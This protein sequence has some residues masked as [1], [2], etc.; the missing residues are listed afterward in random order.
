MKQIEIRF[1]KRLLIESSDYLI[2]QKKWYGWKYLDYKDYSD[3]G[4]SKTLYCNEFK[5]KLLHEVLE[6][7]F[8]TTINN[9]TILEHPTLLRY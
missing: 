4:S 9:I 3:G 7:H 8:S 5:E 2:Q 1:V 6:K